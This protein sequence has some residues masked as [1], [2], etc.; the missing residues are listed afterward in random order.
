MAQQS[1]GVLAP[2]DRQIIGALVIDGRATW[3]AIAGALG[4]SERSVTRHGTALL[5]AGVV[6]IHGM[7]DPHRSGRGDPYLAFGN[8]DPGRTWN[9]AA[10]LARRNES[11]LAYTL[12]GQA[13][14][15]CDLWSPEH[16]RAHLFQHELSD[17]PGV[18]H[19]TVLPVLRYIRTLHDWDP[20]VL[21]EQQ[22]S[23]LRKTRAGAWPQFTPPVKLA[24]EEQ[25]LIAELLRDGRRTFEELSR[26]CGTSEQT[27]ARKVHAMRESQLLAIRAVFDPAVIGL[28]VGA[29]LWLR[30][31]P[32]HV[33]HV[34]HL[35]AQQQYVRY[36][37][38]IMGQFQIVADIRVGSKDE[39]NNVFL[40]APWIAEVEAMDS[41]LILDMLKQGE[42]LAEELR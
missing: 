17:V 24:R 37:A 34:A 42:V 31:K 8:S 35:L 38:L 1:V 7:A 29:L 16:R 18:E 40:H 27:V 20:G 22:V 12:L 39:L 21:D 41:A 2:I 13:D 19:M 4:A 11:V 32:Q 6:E 10:S 23:M 25:L 33:E 30:I 28:P 14:F 9:V 5:Q 36:A 26:L 3:R 15:F